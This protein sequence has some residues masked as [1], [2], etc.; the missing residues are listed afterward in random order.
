MTRTVSV[1]TGRVVGSIGLSILT[2]FFHWIFFRSALRDGQSAF[3]FFLTVPVGMVLGA[4]SGLIMAYTSRGQ[5]GV[6][7][8]IADRWGRIS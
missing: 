3:V 7:G 6:A 5:T 1:I 2:I 4:F 8:H